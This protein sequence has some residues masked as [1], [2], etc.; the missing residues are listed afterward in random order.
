MCNLSSP[1]LQERWWWVLLRLVRHTCWASQWPR[2]LLS[3]QH[4]QLLARWYPPLLVK[5]EA[6]V[7]SKVE[8]VFRS[9]YEMSAMVWQEVQEPVAQQ[10]PWWTHCW[11]VP[12]PSLLSILPKLSPELSMALA[13][14]FS[15]CLNVQPLIKTQSLMN[16]SSDCPAVSCFP[17]LSSL[18]LI[19]S[20]ASFLGRSQ[21]WYG[22]S[23]NWYF[24]YGT[25]SDASLKSKQSKSAGKIN[26]LV[27]GRYW[28]G[29]A[30]SAFQWTHTAFFPCL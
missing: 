8:E 3:Q 4:H 9:V 18:C 25:M 20:S 6:L 26:C 14:A 1:N 16:P 29:V 30:L 5:L 7:V 21:F 15:H 17:P 22:S 19:S 13:V 23:P 12:N 24:L 28:V 2:D 10:V 11:P 27:K